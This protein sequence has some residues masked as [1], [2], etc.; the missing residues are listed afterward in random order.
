MFCLTRF[1]VHNL[2]CCFRPNKQDTFPRRLSKTFFCLNSF[3]IVRN[4]F[5][6]SLIGSTQLSK[7]N[8]QLTIFA[9]AIFLF[10]TCSRGKVID[11]FYSIKA[12][13]RTFFFLLVVNRLLHCAGNNNDKNW[14]QSWL[15]LMGLTDLLCLLSRGKVLFCRCVSTIHVVNESNYYPD[16]Q[17]RCLRNRAMS[18]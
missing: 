4:S 1:L 2:A 9:L 10:A 11:F 13:K 3:Q 7:M 17:T 15:S 5:L 12:R 18:S 14:Q 16:H 6:D 8:T